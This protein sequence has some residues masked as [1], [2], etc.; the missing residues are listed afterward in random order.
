MNP[1]NPSTLIKV[2]GAFLAGLILVMGGALIYS[3]AREPRYTIAAQST[4]AAP[5]HGS[6][7]AETP[8]PK[9]DAHRRVSHA[10]VDADQNP[11]DTSVPVRKSAESARGPWNALAALP[12]VASPQGSQAGMGSTKPAT[13]EPPPAVPAAVP[14]GMEHSA[15]PP[16]T[17]AA[18]ANPVAPPPP[19][20]ATLQPGTTITVQVREMLS[21]DRNRAGDVFRGSLDSPLVVNGFTVAGQGAT[22]LGKVVNAKKARLI[23]SASEL[24]LILT[25]ITT[26][27]GQLVR[28]E[29]S[30]WD[31]EG[32]KV[33]LRDAPKVA[34]GAA[35]GA[36]VGA[37]SGAA[38]GAGVGE[39]YDQDHKTESPGMNQKVIVVPIGSQL[40]F[41]LSSPVKITERP[42]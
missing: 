18:A 31:D 8:A 30:P 14:E 40:T 27:D 21:S 26:S 32:S 13:P 16:V 22:V 3:T 23:G 7:E 34:V 17:E 38:K 11:T 9:N 33:K 10:P 2:F 36:A 42:H 1:L 6:Q 35:Y 29:T 12:V 15:P 28:I 25:E 39:S 41:R 19:S 20:V 37:I 24:T 5:Q 4:P